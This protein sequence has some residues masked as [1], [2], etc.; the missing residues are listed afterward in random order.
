MKFTL[1]L[2]EGLHRMFYIFLFVYLVARNRNRFLTTNIQNDDKIEAINFI[3]RQ[4]CLLIDIMDHINFYY[5]FQVRTFFQIVVIEIVI[6][7]RNCLNFILLDVNS[8]CDCVWEKCFFFLYHLSMHGQSKW[9]V[10]QII[11]LSACFY[12]T[13]FVTTNNCYSQCESHRAGG[14]Y[15]INDPNL[16]VNSNILQIYK[17]NHIICYSVL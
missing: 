1:E 2:S 17:R 14:I 11:I 8:S 16:Q 4:H 6:F 13:S 12:A 10:I 5:A 7:I 3:G 15:L 9:W